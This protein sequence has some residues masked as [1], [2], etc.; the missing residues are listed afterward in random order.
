[1]MR[2]ARLLRVTLAGAVLLV[3]A[4]EPA[5]AYI[6]P[7]GGMALLAQ[8]AALLTVFGVSVVMVL[9]WPYRAAKRFIR[10]LRGKDKEEPEQKAQE[11][12]DSA[13]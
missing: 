8:A 1:M 3:A 12:Q 11:K 2:T 4:H 6:G 7:G 5:A 13:G 10:R 9:T